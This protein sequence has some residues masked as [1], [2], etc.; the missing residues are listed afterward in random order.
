MKKRIDFGIISTP[1]AYSCTKKK[2][3]PPAG[4]IFSISQVK[5]AAPSLLRIC[6]F[7]LLQEVRMKT[8]IRII[9]SNKEASSD[10]GTHSPA[11]AAEQAAESTATHGVSRIYGEWIM[12]CAGLCLCFFLLLT[13]GESIRS[14]SESDGVGAISS[15]LRS[16]ISENDSMAVFFGIEDASETENTGDREIDGHAMTR[17]ESGENSA[18]EADAPTFSLTDGMDVAEYIEKYNT[19][20]YKTSGV[21]PVMGKI[22]SRYSFRKNPFFGVYAD[23]EDEYEF[24][25]GID[26]AADSGTE[27]LC[28]L[29]GTVEKR[30]LSAD[31]GYYL[32]I[33][34]GNGLKT[35]YAH[36]S[37]LFCHEGDK[38]KR[39]QVIGL[40]G[41]T[42]RA[43]G[44]HLHFEVFEDGENVNP[45]KYLSALTDKKKG[46]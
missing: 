1:P 11:P 15:S 25:S 43:T 32:C 28:Y 44:P 36:A 14:I 6:F 30:A 31:Y 29:D 23:E 21:V 39:G 16:L 9:G 20:S 17:Q 24:H 37:E 26:I 42:G 13:S 12:L 8:N 5:A 4:C 33:D 7:R 3:T 10:K 35:L 40:V 27:I 38:V 34:H 22:S 45:D 19:Q 18:A 41:D 2:S 46:T